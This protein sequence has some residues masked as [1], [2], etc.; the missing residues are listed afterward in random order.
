MFTIIFMC[1]EF[2]I[3]AYIAAW[4]GVAASYQY[5]CYTAYRKL[6]R[7]ILQISAIHIDIPGPQSN[8]KSRTEGLA[9]KAEL[10]TKSKTHQHDFHQWEFPEK[11]VCSFNFERFGKKVA[12]NGQTLEAWY[13]SFLYPIR[14]FLLRRLLWF[15]WQS[16]YSKM[17]LTECS[18]S[19]HLLDHRQQSAH[20]QPGG[21]FSAFWNPQFI[22]ASYFS[23]MFLNRTEIHPAEC[24][25]EQWK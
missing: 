12:R 13:R 15:L 17:S 7:K 25:R 5:L 1:F 21:R 19:S 8:Q 3:Y 18:P 2:H 11:H 6:T 10:S 23:L 4:Y 22:I 24:K 14:F 9:C 16:S 20:A